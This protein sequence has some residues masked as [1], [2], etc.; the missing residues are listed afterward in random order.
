MDWR[1]VGLA[2][3]V[4]V[5]LHGLLEVGGIV[6]VEQSN[7]AATFD[8]VGVVDAHHESHVAVAVV[9]PLLLRVELA[10]V[11]LEIQVAAV[12]RHERCRASGLPSLRAAERNAHDAGAK[13]PRL[14]TLSCGAEHR[15]G[16]WC[17]ARATA[18]RLG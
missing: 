5:T 18:M 11:V 16:R 10:L 3:Q 15:L 14:R 17:R 1:W 2:G 7:T 9:A 6:A 4:L 13:S 12:V 8:A